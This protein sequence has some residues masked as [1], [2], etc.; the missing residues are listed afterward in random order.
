MSEPKKTLA[1]HPT[2]TVST[3]PPSRG[4]TRPL[5]GNELGKIIKVQAEFLSSALAIYKM[6]EFAGW[7][8]QMPLFPSHGRGDKHPEGIKSWSIKFNTSPP[9]DPM[10]SDSWGETAIEHGSETPSTLSA[11]SIGFPIGSEKPDYYRICN[12]QFE[13]SACV[14]VVPFQNSKWVAGWDEKAEILLGR[15]KVGSK[16]RK[17]WTLAHEMDHF[18]AY[19]DFWKIMVNRIFRAI[20]MKYDTSDACTK[21]IEELQFNNLRNHLAARKRSAAFDHFPRGIP[22]QGGRYLSFDFLPEEKFSWVPVSQITDDAWKYYAA[23]KN[24]KRLS[25][26]YM[27][28][29][30]Q[31]EIGNFLKDKIRNLLKPDDKNYPALRA[32]WEKHLVPSKNP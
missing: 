15:G 21:A 14:R 5:D 26:E 8:E 3:A 27:A 17:Y 9:T 7:T 30:D 20:N 12:L 1:I 2:E 4:N 6:P 19:F 22:Q 28:Q 32:E 23:N 29:L 13:A 25:K 10:Q 16:E 24:P 31:G 18:N 11:E